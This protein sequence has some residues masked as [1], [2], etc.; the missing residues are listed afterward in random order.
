MAPQMGMGMQQP[1]M[2]MQ[3]QQMPMG[4]QRPT[5]PQQT[6]NDP[7]GALWE[8]DKC[9][10]KF[11]HQYTPYFALIFCAFHYIIPVK[12]KSFENILFPVNCLF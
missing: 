6:S 11:D 10:G 7:F 3:P 12:K 9:W 5:G 4:M 2:G 1:A 8:R